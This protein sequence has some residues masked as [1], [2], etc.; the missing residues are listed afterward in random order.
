M[1]ASRLSGVLLAAFVLAASVSVSCCGGSDA[2]RSDV[3]QLSSGHKFVH[4]G[5]MQTIGDM[6]Y[7]KAKVLSGEEP[8]ASAFERVR[9]AADK[10]YVTKAFT[11]VSTGAYG[12]ND[13]GGRDLSRASSQALNDAYAGYILDDPEYSAKAAEILGAW[14]ENLWDLDGNNAKLNI[15]YTAVNMMHAAEILKYTSSEWTP[16]IDAA[17]TNMVRRVFLPVI[18]DFFPESNGNWDASIM[19]M[20]LCIGVWTEDTEVFNKAL[21]RYCIGKGNGGL[22]KYIYP[23]GQPQ[24]T[25]RDWGHVQ[26]GVSELQKTAQ[27]AYSQGIDLFSLADDRLAIG[28]EYCCRYMSGEPIPVFGE[29]SDRAATVNDIYEPAYN[30]YVLERGLDLPFIKNIVENKTRPRSAIALLISAREP[31]SKAGGTG[32]AQPDPRALMPSVAGAAAVQSADTEAVPEGVITVA[33]GSDIQAALDAAAGSGGTVLLKAGVH[34]LSKTLLLPSGVTLS[35]EG[36][37]TILFLDPAAGGYTIEAAS[38]GISDVVLKN[39]VIEA[40]RDTATASDPNG[41]RWQRV[42]FLSASR[43]GILLQ[44]NTT[45]RIK[46]LSFI[47]LTIQHATKEGLSVSGA[48]NVRIDGCDISDNGGTVVPGPGFHHN[49]HLSYCSGVEVSRSRADDSAFGCGIFAS[50]TENLRISS[51]ETARNVLDGIRLEDCVDVTVENCL[52]EAN[53]GR[54]IADAVLLTGNRNL[55]QSNNLLQFNAIAP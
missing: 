16:E 23:T 24:E 40:G 3:P 22:L 6:E 46:N 27:V 36:A 26:M 12:A 30:F 52:S 1:I 20:M 13:V 42:T 17:F 44:G 10:N 50:M 37:G 41:A 7:V 34:T 48:D 11:H 51:C 19:H 43:G 39:L 55:S 4:P 31:S 14:G 49:I 8:W 45:E 35:G 28:A 53:D 2:V 9:S 38:P 18:K 32:K 29:R 15:G 54:G 25:T 33:P 21:M 47:N 5:M